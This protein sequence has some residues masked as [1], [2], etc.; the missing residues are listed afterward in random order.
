MSSFNIER[1]LRVVYML[2]VPSPLKISSKS[3]EYDHKGLFL[4]AGC[5]WVMSHFEIKMF[6]ICDMSLA[7]IG[8][9]YALRKSS[10]LKHR[11]K[12]PKTSWLCK[13]LQV[14]IAS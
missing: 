8:P 1:S 12:S 6:R 5:V 14:D 7:D 9:G 10:T 11:S 3:V 13:S 4:G 2:C